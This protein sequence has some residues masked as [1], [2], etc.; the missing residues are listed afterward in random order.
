VSLTVSAPWTGPRML[1]G[2]AAAHAEIAYIEALNN[3]RESGRPE[4]TYVNP[5]LSAASGTA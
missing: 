4:M 3:V 1:T 5:M 2:N